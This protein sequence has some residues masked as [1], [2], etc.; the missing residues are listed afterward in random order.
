MSIKKSYQSQTFER[1]CNF[2]ELSVFLQT[3]P[4]YRRRIRCWRRWRKERV[5][6]FPVIL[7][8][9]LWLQSSTGWTRVSPFLFWFIHVKHEPYLSNIYI[10]ASMSTSFSLRAAAHSAKR[11]CDSGSRWKLVLLS[12]DCGRQ[13]RRLHLQHSI[14]QRAYHRPQRA[15]QTHCS[16]L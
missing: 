15:H 11:A 1:L 7:L 4:L 3:L 10:Y 9:A 6:C 12:C 16:S 5:W 2:D 14:P 13:S 8:T